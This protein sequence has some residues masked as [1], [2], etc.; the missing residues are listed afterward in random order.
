MHSDCPLV[1]L[2]ESI[3]TKYASWGW[4]HERLQVRV[5][6]VRPE[7]EWDVGY[8]WAD[9]VQERQLTSLYQGLHGL[10]G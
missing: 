7:V 2:S 5:S 9:L 6:C 4:A 10:M 3:Y 8:L 1:G